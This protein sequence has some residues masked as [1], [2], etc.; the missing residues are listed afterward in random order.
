M[1]ATYDYWLVLLS[2]IVAISAS[3][4]GLNLASRIV[5]TSGRIGQQYWLAGGAI[6]MGT[7]IW[8]MH[9]IGMLA[10]RLPIPISYDVSITLLSLLIAVLSSW[11]ALYLASR[12]TMSLPILLSGGALMGIGIASMHY[13]GMAAMLMT[14][15]I[16]YEPWLFAMSILIAVFASIVAL[17]SAFRRRRETLGSVLWNKA[18]SALVMGS[19]IVGMHYAGMAAASFA[20]DSICAARPQAIDPLLLA[21]ALGAISM[22]FLTTT[23]MISAFDAYIAE[24]KLAERER[25]SRNLHDHVLQAIYAVGMRLE[26][27]QRQ[28]P[29]DLDA[30]IGEI[31]ASL[32]AVIREI[33]GYISGSPQPIRS[34]PQFRAELEKLIEIAEGS[35]GLRFALDADPSA[36]AQLTADEAEHV[37]HVAREAVSNSMRHSRAAR[38]KLALLAADDGVML[39]IA[40]DGI[41]F[42]RNAQGMG[43]S[44][45]GNIRSR[46]REIGARLDISSVPDGGTRIAMHIPKPRTAA[47]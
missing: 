27:T 45:L 29:R 11:F 43:G 3:F 38:G 46:A 22:A 26:E 2:A 1:S 33:R 47:S 40:D 31:I 35:S 23:L 41:G 13:I 21:G 18:G 28:G 7:G 25:L 6:S 5:A 37:L 8:S 17:W 39:E 32:N 19:A 34:Y 30:Q 9:F 20:P 15:P 36:Y 44:G 14:P 42:D 12:G 16:R 4:V 24:A 10:F